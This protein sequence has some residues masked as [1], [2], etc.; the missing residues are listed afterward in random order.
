MIPYWMSN[1][2]DM[3]LYVIEIEFIFVEGGTNNIINN[4]SGT[5]KYFDHRK[6]KY[7]TSIRTIGP[8]GSPSNIYID[9]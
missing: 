7:L 1:N 6:N 4:I 3:N 5:W 2:T 8:Y 9:G